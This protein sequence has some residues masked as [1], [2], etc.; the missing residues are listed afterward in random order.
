MKKLFLSAISAMTLTMAFGQIDQDECNILVDLH[1][2]QKNNALNNWTY[3]DASSTSRNMGRFDAALNPQGCDCASATSRPQSYSGLAWAGVTFQNNEIT[4]LKLHDKLN[5]LPASLLTYHGV[6]NDALT[7]LERIFLGKI[8]IVG[9]PPAIDANALPALTGFNWSDET[10]MTE[11]PDLTNVNVLPNLRYAAYLN[12]PDLKSYANSHVADINRSGMTG[13]TLDNLRFNNAQVAFP[14][15]FSNCEGTLKYVYMGTS[16]TEARSGYWYPSS[17]NSY[18]FDSLATL[19]IVGNEFDN[20]EIDDGGLFNSSDFEKLNE[21]EMTSNKLGGSVP[22]ALFNLKVIRILNL[23]TNNLTGDCV[24][25]SGISV[26]SSLE[27]YKVANNSFGPAKD[28]TANPPN[29]PKS[30]QFDYLTNLTL[31]HLN[32]CGF[33]CDISSL[34]IDGLTALTSLYIENNNFTGDVPSYYGTAFTGLT[35]FHCADNL[36]TSMP[37]LQQDS[38]IDFRINN[39]YFNLGDIKRATHASVSNMVIADNADESHFIIGPQYAKRGAISTVIDA[40]AESIEPDEFAR[41]ADPII[42]SAHEVGVDDFPQLRPFQYH[43]YHKLG[44][45]SPTAAPGSTFNTRNY[46]WGAVAADYSSTSGHTW[47][48]EA[49]ITEPSGLSQTNTSFYKEFNMEV[50]YTTIA[51]NTADSCDFANP[52]ASQG[53]SSFIEGIGNSTT[54]EKETQVADSQSVDHGLREEGVKPLNIY[55]NP[56]QDQVR[57]ECIKEMSNVKVIDLNGRIVLKQSVD[58]KVLNLDLTSLKGGTY[59]IRAQLAS[60]EMIHNR[61]VKSE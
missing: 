25:T 12:F 60:G 43:W 26:T 41:A 6:G 33:T 37:E 1:E 8:G 24:P 40:S 27:V 54:Q 31:L 50:G 21:L 48:C 14:D 44:A 42:L 32:N 51:Y 15:L 38:L 58:G 23:N 2:S 45:G 47:Y 39:N 29:N 55:P 10:L 19:K 46:D 61:I 49:Y 17:M 52:P 13:F 11:L 16:F 22:A 20:T 5:A 28:P 18:S 56:L 30:N 57:I 34:D 59:L 4:E 3:L 35:A 36:L 7:H 53:G 9:V